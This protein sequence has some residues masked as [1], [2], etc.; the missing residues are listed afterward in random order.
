MTKNELIDNMALNAG[1][2]RKSAN[3]ALE[4]LSESII[5]SLKKGERI[6]LKGLGRWTV[7]KLSLIHI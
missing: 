1:I 3:K 5:L 4:A 6:S 2:S 7:Y